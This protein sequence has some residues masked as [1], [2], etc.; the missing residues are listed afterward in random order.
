MAAERRPLR[1]DEAKESYLPDAAED[2]G[3]E[4]VFAIAHAARTRAVA[5][6]PGRTPVTFARSKHIT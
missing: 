1:V 5:R 4:A 6:M 2:L 3:I